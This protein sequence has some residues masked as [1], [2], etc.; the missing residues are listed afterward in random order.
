MNKRI[1]FIKYSILVIN[2]FIYIYLVFIGMNRFI[3]HV[4]YFKCILFLL[5]MSSFVY[6]SS[7]LLKKEKDYK[8]NIVIYIILYLLLLTSI[9]FYIGRVNIHFYNWWY[10]GQYIPFVTIINQFKYGSIYSI[11]KNIIGNSVMLIPL[12]FL[13]MI[14][15]T[16]YKNIIKQSLITIP[17]IIC[18]EVLQSFTHT[19]SFDIDDIILN[20]LGTLIFTFLITRFKF[21]DK[22]RSLFFTDY[23][24]N[25]KL[26]YV[27]FYS[28][29]VLLI[30]F[31][32]T[33]FL[34]L[35]H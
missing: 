6:T 3:Y 25:S 28:S 33:F 9:T 31:D 5:L 23:H 30:I 21:I 18:I 16:K 12:S 4:S 24:L 10:S 29:L 34:G 14:K 26:K 27:I 2:I 20:Y 15:N 8:I 11:L 22:I 13:L 35:I 17:I 7:L 1:V 32:I 19:G